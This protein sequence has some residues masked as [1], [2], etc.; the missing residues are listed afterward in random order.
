MAQGTGPFTTT[1]QHRTS[2][3]PFRMVR[4]VARANAMA[5]PMPLRRLSKVSGSDRRAVTMRNPGRMERGDRVGSSGYVAN[6]SD[7]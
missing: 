7:I 2:R 6:A 1:L 5:A 3:H 4:V